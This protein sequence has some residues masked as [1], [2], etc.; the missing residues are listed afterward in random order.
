GA[1]FS[2]PEPVADHDLQVVAGSVIVRIECAAQL[3]AYSQ[4]REVVRRNLFEAEAQRLGGARQVHICPGAG[5]RRGLEYP[6]TLQ[7]SPLRDGDADAPR[8]Y[9]RKI[10]L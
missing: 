1:E 5:D 9:T 8:A 2:P 10:V 4:D 6:R 3:S 7:I